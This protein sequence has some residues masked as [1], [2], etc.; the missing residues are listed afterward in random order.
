MQ[1]FISDR[2]AVHGGH[3]KLALAAVMGALLA[4]SACGTSSEQTD[5]EATDQQAPA[6]I[7]ESSVTEPTE[8]QAANEA[9]L[10]ENA[11]KDGWTTTE[12]GLQYFVEAAGSEDGAQPVVGDYVSVNYELGLIDG[13]VIDSS[14][15]RGEPAIF[16]LTE[17]LIP[18]WRVGIPLMREGATFQFVMPSDLGYGAQSLPDLPAYST[19]LFKVELLKVMTEEEGIAAMNEQREKMIAAMKADQVAYLEENAKKDGVTTLESGLQ[20]EI[21]ESGAADGPQPGP[22]SDVEVHYRG[23]LIDGSEFDSSYRRGQ[24]AT[25]KPTQVIRGWTEALQL[26]RPGD[27]WKLTIPSDLGYGDRGSGQNIPPFATLVFEVEVV[28]VPGAE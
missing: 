3:G 17:R 20:Y 14:F 1:S 16:L 22:N 27:K 10:T 8:Y 13:S 2:A 28:S 24:T 25:F 21:L 9:Y 11:A 5:P 23:T 26:M 19:L 18:G 4:L 12:E 6:N 15:A 7:E